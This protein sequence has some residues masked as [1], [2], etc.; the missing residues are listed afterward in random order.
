MTNKVYRFVP[1]V[2]INRDKM[3]NIAYYCRCVLSGGCPEHYVRHKRSCY[4]F[5]PYR[6]TWIE[7]NV[8]PIAVLL[9]IDVTDFVPTA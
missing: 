7:A 4:R 2:K 6:M 1:I 3:Q 8:S 9:I 5:Y